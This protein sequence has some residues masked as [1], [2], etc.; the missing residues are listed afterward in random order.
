MI[1][2]FFSVCL[3]S[4]QIFSQSFHLPKSKNIHENTA[5][6]IIDYSPNFLNKILDETSILDSLVAISAT[7]TYSK[8]LFKYNEDSRMSEWLI[9]R[10]GVSGLDSIHK[11]T[12]NYD[13]SYNLLS[14][15]AFSWSN[16]KWDSIVRIDYSYIQGREFQYVYQDFYDNVWRNVSRETKEY[17]S[18]GL[19]KT[20]VYEI[21]LE[22][23]WQNSSIVNSFYSEFGYKDSLVFKNWTNNEW[24]NFNKTI[25]YYNENKMDLDSLIAT[26]W[27]GTLWQKYFKRIVTNDEY[28]NQIELVDFIYTMNGWQNSLRYLYAYNDFKFIINVH[29]DVWSGNQWTLGNAV[30]YFENPDGFKVGIETNNIQAHYS[31]IVD[32]DNFENSFYNKFILSQN[33]PNPF[34]PTTNIGYTIPDPSY[35]EIKVYDVLGNEI[36]TLVDEHKDKGIYQLTFNQNN[37]PSGIYFYKIKSGRYS[38]TRKMILQK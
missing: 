24:V 6:N 12:F 3:F 36:E 29:C 25:F 8:H 22:N 17:N 11:H 34:N 7:G 10:N 26:N 14:E 31:K 13:N 38:E 19:L 15:I 16:S 9:L 33:Y 37:L 35:V 1:K 4:I 23:K 30:I 2:Y 28:H 20:S 5:F 32:V 18:N 27:T 21:W